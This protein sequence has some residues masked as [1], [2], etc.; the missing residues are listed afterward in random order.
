MVKNVAE[1]SVILV[2]FVITGKYPVVN[3]DSIKYLVLSCIL[4]FNKSMLK[5]PDNVRFFIFII[6]FGSNGSKFGSK[7]V[8]VSSRLCGR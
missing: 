8:N 6:Y 2:G 7:N 5:S 1:W 4:N 3:I